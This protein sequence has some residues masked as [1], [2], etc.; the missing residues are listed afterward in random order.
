V[1][2]KIAK[3]APFTGAPHINAPSVFGASTGK[4]MFY[5]IPVTGARPITVTVD[6]LPEGFTFDG[7]ILAGKSDCDCTF[8]LTIHAE[9]ALGADESEMTVEIAP[10]HMLRTPL[11]GFTT[12]NAFGSKVTQELAEETAKKLADVGLMEYGYHYFNI[13]SG[14]Q[15]EYGG[16]YDAIQPNEKFP[17]MGAMCEK[18]HGMGF[19]CGIYSTPMLTAWGCPEELPSIPGCTRGEPDIRFASMNG[20]IGT[21][22]MEEN[23]VKQWTEWGFDYL[24]YDWRPCD[25]INADYMKRALLVSEREI[26]FCVTVHADPFYAA[27]WKKNCCSWRDNS[28]SEPRW[29]RVMHLFH[30]VDTWRPHVLP[31]HFYDLDMLELGKTYYH[32]ENDWSLTDDE[33]LFAYTMR[34]FFASPIQISSAIDK[35]S[36]FELD[37]LC[38]EEILAINQDCLA[39]YPTLAAESGGV[40]CYRR[41]LANGDIAYAIFNTGDTPVREEIALDAPM[42]IRD[43]WAKSDLGCADTLTMEADAH[44]AQVYRLKK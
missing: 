11:L 20:G 17:D 44:S 5:R 10:D 27:Y 32:D 22:R 16:R 40:R 28:D 37:L 33:K 30:T 6:G 24:K 7:R 19:H 13:D 42:H 8:R 43:V 26:A 35:L 21:E 41:T 2:A 14:W 3:A 39:D 25:G 29:E 18:L 31:G 1:S 15:K 34:A 36:E 23:N 12:W 4:A 38:N 9:N